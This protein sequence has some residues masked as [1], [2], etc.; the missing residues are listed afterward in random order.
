VEEEEEE[1]EERTVQGLIPLDPI[2][3]Y[4]IDTS[5]ALFVAWLLWSRRITHDHEGRNGERSR[6][7]E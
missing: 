1:E 5:V 3:A 6:S 4:A 7:T 2:L